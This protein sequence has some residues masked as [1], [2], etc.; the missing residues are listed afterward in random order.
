MARKYA[1]FSKLEIGAK[2]KKKH[3]KNKQG[4]KQKTKT[5]ATNRQN[6]EEKKGRKIGK[7]LQQK[8]IELKKSLIPRGVTEKLD[9]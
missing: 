4:S 2:I 1:F 8:K 9:F 5:G 3:I 7:T 6:I